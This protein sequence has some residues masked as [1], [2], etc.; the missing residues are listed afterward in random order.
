MADNKIEE[1]ITIKEN[2]KEPDY[3]GHRQRLKARF[4][5][6][7]GRSM[8][9][10]ELLELVLMYAIPRKDVKPIAK[11]L[12]KEYKTL[13][14]VLAAEQSSLSDFPGLGSNAVT[15]F[16]LIH[17][18]VNKICWENLEKNGSPILKD[19]L[20][21]VEY[22]RAQIGYEKQ[23][24][25]LVIY[26]G[27]KGKYIKH[28]VEQTGTTSSVLIN[29]QQIARNALLCNASSVIVSHNHPSGD[30][31][32]SRS[33]IEMTLKLKQSLEGVGLGLTD[34]IIISPKEH[35]SFYEKSYIMQAPNGKVQMI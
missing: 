19:M 13:S 24:K 3:I 30:C 16:S 20:E 5:T 34:H 6:D 35:Y 21:V 28:S 25:L 22:C 27:N 2:E 26:L 4:L 10:Y 12:L 33:D 8:P 15:L 7:K 23:E 32:P 31:S 29:P 1:N 18:C 14:S 9:D 17:A 11:A